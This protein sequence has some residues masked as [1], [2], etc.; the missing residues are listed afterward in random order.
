MAAGIMKSGG[1]AAFPTDTVYGL[2]A[3]Y[4][5]IPAIE[6]VYAIKERRRSCA[7]PL[8]VA[9]ITQLKTIVSEITP[10]ACK[11]I[12]AFWPGALTI[13]LTRSNN[14]PDVVTGGK[15]TVAVRLPACPVAVLLAE[16]TGKPICGTSA[17]ISGQASATSGEEVQNTLGHRVDFIVD[18][19]RVESGVESTII[20]LTCTVP[21][22]LRTGPVGRD[23]IN[24]ICS[25][26]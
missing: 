8:I 6:R 13:I 4:D 3:C 21:R 24:Q 1:V 11:L 17:N 23:R 20:D 9:N 2:G 22:I 7:L 15:N 19:G 18:G 5:C 26:E 10:V 16:R 12:D 14:V 25:V